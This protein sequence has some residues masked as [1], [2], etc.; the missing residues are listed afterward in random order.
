MRLRILLIT[1]CMTSIANVGVYSQ[2]VIN[3]L[4]GVYC[5]SDAPD[6]L[7]AV[8]NGSPADVY[9]TGVDGQGVFHPSVAGPGTH[10]ITAFGDPDLY[11]V[12]DNGTFNPV[13]GSG[14]AV[15]L[16]DDAVVTGLPVGFSFRF[17]EN[18]YNTFGISSNGFLF[19][20]SNNDN[21]CCTGQLLP[22]ATTPNDLIAFAWEDLDPD[23]A[24][25]IEYFTIGTPPER[26]LI[27]NIIDV[28]HFP[29]PGPNNNVT[30]QVQL[31]E[32][33][34]RIE[35][36]TTSQPDGG[37]IHTMGIE[38]AGGTLAATPVG[39]NAATWTATNDFVA[40]VPAE[41]STDTVI[42]SGGPDLTAMDDSVVCFGDS[43]ASSSVIATGGAPFTYLWS[44][45]STSS[46]VSGLGVGTYTCSV[47]DNS[48]CASTIDIEVTSPDPIGATFMETNATCESST[49]GSAIAAVVGGVEP[50][51]YLW[52]DPNNSTTI[53]VS[54]LE[55]G[56][57]GFTATDANGCEFATGIT[58]G[59]DNPDP[60]VDLGEDKGFCPGQSAVLVGP[61]GEDNYA[62]SNGDTIL[63]TIVSSAGVYSLTVTSNAGCSASDDVTVTVYTPAQVDLGA[64]Q[65]GPVP[66]DI[67]AGSMFTNFLWSTG[68]NTQIVTASLSGEYSVTVTDSNGCKSSDSVLIDIWPSGVD[69]VQDNRLTLYPNPAK[70]RV[71]IRSDQLITNA[72]LTVFDLSGR[73]VHAVVTDMN[74]GQ[75]V[76]LDLSAMASGTYFVRVTAEGIVE[77]FKV[78]LK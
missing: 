55:P 64:N 58:I 54:G 72:M 11:A 61:A 76:L 39:R 56:S 46:S 60:D 25:T 53:D 70:D 14:T 44:N 12:I 45:G 22:S 18:N 52:A 65:S 4:N 16:G 30:T 50:Y 29:G 21:G 74:P 40:F 27:V 77:D 75:E 1:L 19:F 63:S 24:G 42:V 8:C 71:F 15:L 41:C 37:Q 67:D 7:T 2:C 26:R 23:G 73:E 28:P 57:Y 68:A 9:G 43:N 20:G 51:T 78:T 47:T 48:G 6:T 69:E 59:F 5:S 33:C 36:H 31:W 3:G 49:D 10:V 35:I 66:V 62:W 38:K 34:G 17:Y 32:G 13:P